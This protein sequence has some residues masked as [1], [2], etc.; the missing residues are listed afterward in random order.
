MRETLRGSVD[1]RAG[2]DGG[3]ERGQAPKTSLPWETSTMIQE[4]EATRM[5]HPF[6]LSSGLLR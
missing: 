2:Q 3:Q 1:G 5:F 4:Q 6:D